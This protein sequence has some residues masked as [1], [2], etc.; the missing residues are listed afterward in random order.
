[1]LDEILIALFFAFILFRAPIRHYRLYLTNDDGCRDKQK[2]LKYAKPRKDGEKG[3]LYHGYVINYFVL[4]G[5]ERDDTAQRYAKMRFNTK[6]LF[7][8]ETADLPVAMEDCWTFR[9]GYEWKFVNTTPT[10]IWFFE[11]ETGVLH[12]YKRELLKANLLLLPAFIVIATFIVYA[13]DPTFQNSIWILIA[14][15]LTVF[16]H[17]VV[18]LN[19]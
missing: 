3:V 18:I 13:I 17:F 1:M 2:L 9:D 15:A 19:F 4:G 14:L 10:W 5:D 8:N 12:S 16:E 6:D 7:R 11:D